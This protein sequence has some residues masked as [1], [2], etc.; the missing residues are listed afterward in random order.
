LFGGAL[1]RTDARARAYRD[2]FTASPPSSIRSCSR[3]APLLAPVDT[4]CYWHPG[5]SVQGHGTRLALRD[6]LIVP[7]RRPDVE[8]P[9]PAD[10]GAGVRDHLAPVR[11]PSDAA[12]DREHHRE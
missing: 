9:R 8:L 4:P 12:R 2:V 5:G 6:R 1:A 3:D 7:A 11:D 10:A